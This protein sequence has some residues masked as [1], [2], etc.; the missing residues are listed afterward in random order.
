MSFTIFFMVGPG[1][2]ALRAGKRRAA[3]LDRAIPAAR[4]AVHRGDKSPGGKF[5]RTSQAFRGFFL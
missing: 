5:C 2:P 3:G 4:R 1:G